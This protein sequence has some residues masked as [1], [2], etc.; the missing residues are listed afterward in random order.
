M[1]PKTRAC[2]HSDNYLV[3]VLLA[4]VLRPPLLVLPRRLV[5]VLLEMQ[6]L[7]PVQVQVSLR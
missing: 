6:L 2:T 7:A 3:L 1:K 4:R 5:L